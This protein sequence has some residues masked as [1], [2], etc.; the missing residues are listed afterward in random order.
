M[1]V[2]LICLKVNLCLAWLSIIIV[3]CV[4]VWLFICSGSMWLW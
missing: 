3:L 2:C 4:F 1:G